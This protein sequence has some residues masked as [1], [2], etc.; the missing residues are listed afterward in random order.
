MASRPNT[1]DRLHEGR[2][3]FAGERSSKHS[4]LAGNRRD[5]TTVEIVAPDL[6][7]LSVLRPE[8]A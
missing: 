4:I 2:D 8:F 7:Q 3:D 5:G 1:W 6:E